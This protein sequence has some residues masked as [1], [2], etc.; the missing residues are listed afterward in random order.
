VK[1]LRKHG[2]YMSGT[3]AW[4]TYKKNYDYWIA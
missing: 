4:K 3:K 2:G 1:Q